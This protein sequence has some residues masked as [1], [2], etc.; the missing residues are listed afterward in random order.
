VA[1]AIGAG[2]LDAA[3]LPPGMMPVRPEELG[4][5]FNRTLRKPA[6]PFALQVTP[7]TRRN[8]EWRTFREAYKGATDFVTKFVWPVPAFHV[9]RWCAARGLTP[10]MVTSASA[11]LM[12]L[13]TWLFWDGYLLPGLA[14]AWAMTFLD[15]VDGKLARCTLTSSR[16]G[17]IFDH[18][19]DLLHPPFWWLAWWHGVGL[20]EPLA[21]AG[22]LWTALLVILAG[23]VGLRLLEG[24]FKLAFGIQ[25]HIWRPIDY[26]FRAIT[27]RRNPNLAILTVATCLGAPAAGFLAVAGWTLVSIAFH[28]VRIGQ[29]ARVRLG[30]GRV[31]SWLETPANRPPVGPAPAAALAAPP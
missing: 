3:N 7:A 15:T 17:N 9:T 29:A 1:E 5:S 12:L 8:A 23:Y 21:A 6:R 22:P 24:A 10:N 20:V 27:S 30:G 16:W 25:T 4:P 31:T 11:I 13:A 2:V 28:L 19:I 14:V 18:G 26:R